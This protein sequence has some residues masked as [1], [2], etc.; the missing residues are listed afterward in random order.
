MKAC[1]VYVDFLKLY[2]EGTFK[3]RRE[4]ILRQF[5]APRGRVGTHHRIK[6]ER[7]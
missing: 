6:S 1:L 2:L 4:I 7:P 3:S 5:W